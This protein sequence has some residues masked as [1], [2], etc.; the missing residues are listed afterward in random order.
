ML[1]CCFVV[2]CYCIVI[3]FLVFLLPVCFYFI[4]SLYFIF[5]RYVGKLC[6]YSSAPQPSTAHP[7]PRAPTTFTVPT[8]AQLPTSP[9][10]Q[11]PNLSA[12]PANSQFSLTSPTPFLLAEQ[13][14][15][16][17]LA[18]MEAQMGSY[19]PLLDRL[20]Q[21]MTTVE[22]KVS[23]MERQTSD[24]NVTTRRGSHG[25]RR[26]CLASVVPN[27]PYEPTILEESN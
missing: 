6:P 1:F 21:V 13:A 8:I 19:A 16:R 10:P 26:S 18:A 3:V 20:T 17:R 27:T 15:E 2:I 12:S 23:S 9:E 5:F 25:D 14:R 7:P 22:A 11:F 4:L 24:R